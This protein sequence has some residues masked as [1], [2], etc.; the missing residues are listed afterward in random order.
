MSKRTKN[1][2]ESSDIKEMTVEETYRKMDQRE[3]VL[4]LPDTYIGSIEQDSA[5]LWVFDD[6]YIPE[7]K[8]EI[9]DIIIKKN[10]LFVPGFYK[11]VDELIVNA[12]DHQ[13]RDPDC[14]TIK[15]NINKE[16]GAITIW[17]N[18]NGI[19][20]AIH[21]DEKIYV[22]ELI[23]GNLLTSSNYETK[24]KIVGGKNGL[25]A[26]VA[27]I[28]SKRFIVETVDAKNKKKY[29][30]EFR[31]NM[32]EK[33]EP[34][35]TPT[36]K[37]AFSYTQI[38]Y[39]PDYH[40]FNMKG[41]TH[42][43]ISLLKKRAYD[44]AA[45]THKKVKVYLNDKLLKINGFDDF[46][47]LH[48]EETP[49][50]L[51]EEINDRWKIGIVFKQDCGD[52]QISFVNG[53][54]TYS[55]GTHVE[56]IMKQIVDKITTLI[57]S[58]PLNKTLIIK[59]AQIKE[60]LT[61]FVDAVIDD[62]SFSS[63]TKGQLTTKVSNFGTTCDI[64]DEFIAKLAKTKLIDIV[65]KNA[66][67]KEMSSLKTTDGKKVASIRDI[68]KLEDAIWAGTRKS[69]E[70]RLIL[71]EGDSAKSF[72]IAGLRIIG[73]ERFGVFPLKG[74]VINVRNKTAVQIK[75]N[76]EFCHLKK[77]LGLKQETIYNDVTKLRYGG[78]IIL[79]DQDQDGSHIKGLLINMF[80]YF[81]PDLLRID[82]F[83]QTM[84]TPLLKAFKKTDTKKKN[85]VIFYTNSEYE[86]WAKTVDSNKYD[87]KYYKG[88]GTSTEAEA[89]EVFNDFKN[90]ISSFT[91]ETVDINGN[92]I[93]DNKKH[94]GKKHD[95]DIDND[96]DDDKDN[97]KEDDDNDDEDNLSKASSINEIIKNSVS[98]NSITL[99][100]D[101]KRADH[102]KAWLR[103]YNHKD[104][105]NYTSNVTY[106]DFINK[107]LIH[108]SNADNIRSLPSIIDG[109]K[110]S[111]R[112]IAH[113]CFDRKI[114]KEIKVAQLASSVAERTAYK[115][116]ET[117]LQETIINM[118][119]NFPGS[120]NI[121]ILY[122]AGC[123]GHRKQGGKEAS[124]PRYIYTYLTPIA[125]KIFRHE[126][127][128]ILNYL[129]DEG[130]IVEPD[131]FLP[132]IPMIL[133]NGGDG[134]GTGFSTH[135]PP[136]NPIDIC[137]NL[138]RRF[139]NKEM[140]DM[141][142]YYQGFTGNIKQVGEKTFFI[143][144]KYEISDDNIVKVTEIPIRGN[145]CWIDKYDEFLKTLID[146][147]KD[148]SSSNKKVSN[149]K[150]L[151]VISH[152]GNNE[153]DF[154]IIFKGNELQKMYKKGDNDIE[155]FLKLSAN[156]S[157][158]NIYLY[159]TKGVITPYDSP[160]EIMEEFFEFRLDM[161]NVRRKHH[162]KVLSNELE[163]IKNKVRFITDVINDNIII[164]KEKK[165]K[166]IETLVKMNYPKLSTNINATEDEKS[167]FYALDMQLFSQT[168]EKVEELKKLYQDK[169]K[170]YDDY[171]SITA[172]ELWR[173]ELKEFMDAYDIWIKECKDDKDTMNNVKKS[174]K[175]TN[176]K[177]KKK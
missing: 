113:V 23:F 150:V 144:G 11:T 5:N 67:F 114:K 30:Q 53:I 33:D 110:P 49:T 147:D 48:Y 120:N 12:R 136:Y 43:V 124:N 27:N 127:E 175:D 145:Y 17:N 138:L 104:V 129:E 105:L 57:K 152:C 156:I 38:T 122:P 92:T 168:F 165:D 65:I 72:A 87:I 125:M 132:I 112:K 88:L 118:A 149:K 157:V 60:H 96:K 51:Y 7:G 89:R 97:D 174:K 153:I 75:A 64:N 66:K 94:K 161:Y 131:H 151:D 133:V 107:E 58:Q 42:D 98:Y 102:R 84:T 20:V 108:F 80:Q 6:E 44:I 90:R 39:Y 18:G 91:W 170:E 35:I 56:Y 135:V 19:P 130:D 177:S 10:I 154:E 83:I 159:N 74:K 59:P 103:K 76:K 40:R 73:R 1:N 99:A 173:R 29:I 69:K 28:F 62:P 93:I 111:Q 101:K 24:G 52:D 128:S 70:T 172:I 116:G 171:N 142:P 164:R 109:F 81:W 41:L 163:I 141:I 162:L 134:I 34:T 61:L 146:D 79:T 121:N 166:V 176:V 137:K 26:K 68:P 47:K 123:F 77:I 22:P 37:K 140:F 82:D 50:L 4:K 54:W 106:S 32:T 167:Y 119:Q 13:V 21:K 100:F 115:H 71:T 31:N 55:G 2:K 117:S 148:K 46:I 8:N 126:D 25:G 15:I 160:I 143:T 139:D 169:Q 158:S 16:S 9:Q 63:Q 85:G 95:S 155:K 86:T 3:H 36:D 45:C 14:D 78:I